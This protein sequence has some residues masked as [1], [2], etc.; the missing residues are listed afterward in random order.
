MKKLASLAIAV[1]TSALLAAPALAQTW[2]QRPVKFIV[3]LG[4][5][6]GADITARLLGDR[7][8]KRWG[9]PVVVENRPG[10]NGVIAINALFAARDDHTLLFGPTSAIVA[11]PYVLD[12]LPY[13][14]RDLVPV[15]RVT[16]T[17]VALAA[18]ASLKVQSLKELMAL[19]REEPGKLNWTT[20]TPM[21]DIIVGGA[22]KR[23]GLDMAQVRYKDA[24]SALNDLV[25]GRIQLYS[26][27]YAIMRAQA[28]AGRVRPL[29]VQNRARA[30]GLDLP[31][32]AEA[33]FPDFNFDGLVG[34]FAARV[35]GLSDAT[36]ERIAADVRAVVVEPDVTE[37]L[38][39]I[40]L[41]VNPGSAAEFA[42][43]MD[44]QAAQ[45]A[46]FAKALGLK[47][48]E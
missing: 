28:Q 7:L 24:V 32:V 27:A 41:I 13:D 18:P 4:P 29:A 10:A 3:S 12:K 17:V 45:L 20:I 6:S 44:E 36:R 15:A 31:T 39:A 47:P 9:Q 1:V 38:T 43:A 2:P 8:A 16:N 34:L 5:G 14:P 26:A 33:G 37:R 11:H 40:G 22:L 30:P 23:A 21:T 42:A 48:K 19:V 25:E 35:S 46:T